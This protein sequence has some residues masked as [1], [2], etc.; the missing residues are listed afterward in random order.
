PLALLPRLVDSS[1][2]IA[3]IDAGW[4]GGE[5]PLAALAGDQQAATFG[6]VCL[7]PGMAKNTYGTGCF[8]LMNAGRQ[9]MPSH[10]RLLSTV[11]W[12]YG[13]QT[14][15]LLEGSVFMG[16]AVVQWLRDGPGMGA[17]AAEVEPLAA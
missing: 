17:S 11:G 6:Q 5:I 3:P 9:A 12:R 7:R 13:G 10:H 8:L 1:G 15:Y 16:G 14:T 2:V 4:L